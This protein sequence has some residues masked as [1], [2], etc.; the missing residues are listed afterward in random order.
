MRGLDELDVGGRTVLLRADLNV[1][2]D[3]VKITDDGRIRA[4]LPTITRLAGRGARIMIFAHLGRPEGA[5][6]AE[7]AAGGPSLEPVAERLAE[8]LGREVP[9]AGDVAGASAAAVAAGLADGGVAMAEN[10][11][12]EPAETSKDDAERAGLARRMA[13]LAGPDGRYVGDGFGAL[14]RKHASVYD[15]PA[16]LPHAAGDL[17]LAEVAVLRRLTKDPQRPYVVVLGGAKPSDKLAVIANLLGSADRLVIG[18]GMSYTFLK[19]QGHEVGKSLLEPDMIP[20]VSELLAE[21]ARRG[22]EVVLPVDLVAATHYAPDAEHDIVS[23]GDFPADRESMDMGPATRALF[24]EKIADAKTV[25]WN[26]PVGVFEFPAFAAGTRAVAEAISSVTLAGLTVVG[27][28]DSAA[29]VRILG[30][31]EESFTHVSTGGGA[32]LEYLEGRRLPGLAALEQ[33]APA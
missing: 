24:A 30:F 2:L 11:R 21:A 10:V 16:L 19:A 4:S 26:G 1:P 3:G 20:R 5:G 23:V 14:H 13:E 12:F 31:P 28:G 33:G 7:R 32:S 6:Y 9:L 8:L 17:V 15:L 27:G 22:V 18:G 29:A 25:F